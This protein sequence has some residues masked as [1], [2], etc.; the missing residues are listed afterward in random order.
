M[1][2]DILPSDSDE[3]EDNEK[4][5]EEK[6]EEG[7]N[8]VSP[9]HN[10][11]NNNKDNKK[12]EEGIENQICIHKSLIFRD[13]LPTNKSNHT[14]NITKE[15]QYSEHITISPII[16]LDYMNDLNLKYQ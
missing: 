7:I 14:A 11:N 5:E 4:E 2:H 3:D 12:E 15:N 8:K 16:I 10:D 9:N 1:L 13:V 6:A